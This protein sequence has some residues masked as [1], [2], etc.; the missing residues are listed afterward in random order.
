MHVKIGSL[1]TILQNLTIIPQEY[2]LT[3]SKEDHY[4]P[5]TQ[6]RNIIEVKSYC[7]LVFTILMVE[8]HAT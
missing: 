1:L 7:I 3:S 2:P 5:V 8:A 6:E 4:K